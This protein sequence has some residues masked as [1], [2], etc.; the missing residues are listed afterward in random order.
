MK[1]ATKT[2]KT[3]TVVTRESEYEDGRYSSGNTYWGQQGRYE[4]AG[5]ALQAL[6]PAVG[7]VDEPKQ[8]PRLEKF[9]KASNCYYDLY[10]NGLG[11][12]ASEFSKVFGIRSSQYRYKNGRYGYDFERY[13]YDL[14]EAEM[15]VIIAE[16]AAEQGIDLETGESLKPAVQT[17]WAP[18]GKVGRSLIT[19]RETC[20]WGEV[21]ADGRWTGSRLWM[22]VDGSETVEVNA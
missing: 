11:N 4:K 18:T 7:S 10:N 14:V 9:R 13:L 3:L 22:S 8:N 1:T 2:I 15:S 6:V 21:D 16:A 12:R 5:K 20:E 19:G 17:R